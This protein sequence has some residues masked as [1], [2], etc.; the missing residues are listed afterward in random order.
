MNATH[1]PTEQSQ[2][3][4]SLL[5]KFATAM[6]VSRTGEHGFH[7]RP[8]AFA[9]I[10]DDGRL[11]FITGADTAKVHE[12]EVDSHVHLTAQ[13]GNSAFVSLSGRASLVTDREKI[14]ELWSEPF[15]AWFPQGKDDPA[16]ELIVVY[17]ERGEFWDSSG[18]NRY[19]YLWEAAKAYW[20]GTT[21]EIDEGNMHGTFVST[22]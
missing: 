18:A 3:F 8:M 4:I 11:W 1:S 13:D 19:K 12:I 9:K 15:R 14:A 5:K 16:I 7:A 10:E 2:H 22:K 21:P 6:L 17:P 20:S